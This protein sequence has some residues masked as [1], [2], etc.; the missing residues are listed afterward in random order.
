MKKL[1]QSRNKKFKFV[2]LYLPELQELWNLLEQH[3]ESLEVKADQYQIENFDDF[4]T[5]K[6]PIKNLDITCYRPYV[7]IRISPLWCEL[8]IL[9]DEE[10]TLGIFEKAKEILNKS[11]S[12]LR[13]LTS[14][15]TIWVLIIADGIVGRIYDI[16][17]QYEWIYYPL[18]GFLMIFSL[19][20]NLRKQALV[21]PYERKAFLFARKKDDLI[22][23]IIA[24]AAG[25][26][27]TLLVQWIWRYIS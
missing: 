2:R 15:V 9:E 13:F 11:Q 25:S 14:Y 4:K 7:S 20:I 3:G 16:P 23:A 17:Y 19:Y 18:L 24:A 1:N 6:N 10:K 26:V 5:I 21:M 22:I 27:F 12:K 8:S